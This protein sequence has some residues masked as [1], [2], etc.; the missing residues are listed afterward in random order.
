MRRQAK[1]I[2]FGILY[3]MGV[4]ALRANLGEGTSRA[5][6][7]EFLKECGLTDRMLI[8]D[9]YPTIDREVQQFVRENQFKAALANDCKHMQDWGSALKGILTW[10]G[11]KNFKDP[12]VGI[13]K[14]ENVYD[15][16]NYLYKT[17]N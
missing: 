13:N 10:L 17:L 7:Q 6:A 1:V 2:N 16:K 9:I 5:E 12:K 14:L 8:G 4:N 15:F 11:E 3:G